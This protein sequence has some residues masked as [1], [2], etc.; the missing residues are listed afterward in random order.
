[1]V[2]IS[3]QCLQGHEH[4]IHQCQI[5]GHNHLSMSTRTQALNPSMPDQCS[6]SPINVYKDTS[7]WFINAK[8]M[9]TISYQCL[10]R[11]KHIINQRRTCRR[12]QLSMST[13][14]KARNRSTPNQWAKSAINVYTDTSTESINAKPMGTLSYQCQ[15]GHKHRSISIPNQWAQSSICLSKQGMITLSQ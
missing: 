14:T 6:Q 11:H 1:M 4:L 8:P 7:T 10:H 2:T 12:D 9:G 5:N 15:H 13:Q 3:Y